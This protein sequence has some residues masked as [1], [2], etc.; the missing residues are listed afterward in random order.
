VRFRTR[1]FA[2][3][4]LL[5]LLLYASSLAP[6]HR[7]ISASFD[8]IARDSFDG[9]KQSLRGIQ[10]EQ[11]TRMR[12]ECVLIMNI[13]ELRALI[14]ESS[15]ELTADNIASLNERLDS[16]ANV[17]GVP[18]IFILDQ[19]GAVVAQRNPAPWGTLAGLRTFLAQ[20]AQAR[21]LVGRL[22]DPARATEAGPARVEYGI[23]V[24][25][26]QLYQ[27][28]GVPLTFAGQGGDTGIEGAMIMATPLTDAQAVELARRHNCAV[29]FVCGNAIVA[30]SHTSAERAELAAR[31]G[32][33]AV[34]LDR[35]FIMSLGGMAY[36][37]SFDPLVDPCSHVQVGGTLVQSSMQEAAA[38][39][40]RVWRD[41]AL[42]SLAGLAM[43]AVA[44]FVLST[45][46]TRP[47]RRLL[48]GVRRVGTGDM[49]VAIDRAGGGELGELAR[50]F[51]DMVVKL[52]QQREL[53]RQ[54]EE[55]RIATRAKSQFLANMSHEIRTPLN[56]VAGMTELL[57]RTELT[58]QQ[59]RYVGL[60][61][62]SSK[63]LA[64]VINDILDFSKIEAGKLEL[65]AADFDLGTTVTEVVEL[66]TPKA[67]AKGL[68]LTLALEPGTPTA[69]RGDAKRLQ[70]I[71]I[72]LIN[73][74]LKF[75][76]T[77]SV[78]VSAGRETAAGGAGVGIRFAVTDTGIGIP[79]DRIGRLF[80]SFSQVDAST[81][82]K[83]GGTGLGLAIC[84]QLAELMGGTIGVDSRLGTGSCF[85]FTARFA[86]GTAPAAAA[87]PGPAL[88]ARAAHGAHILVAEDNEINQIV[89]SEALQ[90]AGHTCDLVADGKA[91]LEA[92]AGKHYDLV[93]M[94]CQMPVM[95]GFEATRQVR[96]WEQAQPVPEGGTRRR[97]PV[98][99]LTA[100]ATQGDRDLCL[101]CGMDDYVSKPIDFALL[102]AAID[103][104]LVRPA[105]LAPGQQSGTGAADAGVPAINLEHLQ[106]R[107]AKTPQLLPTLLDRFQ[108]QITKTRG[109]LEAALAQSEL[110][111]FR[112][113]VHSMKGSAGYLAAE[114]LVQIAGQLEGSSKLGDL[115]AIQRGFA[116]M[117]REM[118]ACLRQIPQVRQAMVKQA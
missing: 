10:A 86:A 53:E 92:L 43:A 62:T 59:A 100:S 66:L 50:A 35:D 40:G 41:L 69:L 3:W 82:R 19:R 107:Y 55:S 118:D 45:T 34:P 78:T 91:V 83:Y 11:V 26:K 17:V 51:N 23:W 8:R 104:Y 94:D 103:R 36:Q 112:A 52:R 74:A 6:I 108:A 2:A 22:Y 79:A 77:G 5:A 48:A 58:H 16:L 84:K 9:T 71:L 113:L 33:N 32:Q 114:K 30:S 106:A 4:G 73:N 64:N 68:Q 80:Q 56:G 61:Q 116:E 20:S 25:E 60:L 99:A 105:A 93:L 102:G 96:L 72:N 87:A 18:A 54:V 110:D 46:V 24:V 109:E 14:A 15:S 90:S 1:L 95:D 49:E 57:S 38:I 111:G 81:T 85:W 65:E 89:V 98:I 97:I 44:S 37:S 115:Q 28:V 39:Q 70:Q 117:Q 7:T 27:T 12:Q 76:E 31:L 29:S 75:T 63:I 13:P 47:V 21:A 67:Q 42:I 88:P 101:K